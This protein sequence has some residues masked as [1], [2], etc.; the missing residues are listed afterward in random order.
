M[1]DNTRLGVPPAPGLCPADELRQS[2]SPEPKVGEQL[3]HY[4]LEQMI[5]QGGMGRVFRASDL[6]LG[7][8]L[9]LKVMLPDVAKDETHRH[10]F[11][12]EAGAMAALNHPHVVPIL[13]VD[14]AGPIPYFVMPLLHGETLQARLSRQPVLPV[15]DVIRIGRQTA[16]GLAHAHE[17]GLIHRDVKPAN[18]WLE[19]GSGQVKI[20]DFGLVRRDPE[21]IALTQTGMVLGTFGFMAPEQ[22]MGREVDHRCDQYSLGCTLYLACTGSRAAH[23]HFRSPHDLNANVPRRLG[24]VIMRLLSREPQDRFLKTGDVVEALSD[25]EQTSP[26][27]PPTASRRAYGTSS[28]IHRVKQTLIGV[29]AQAPDATRGES[30]FY[31][32]RQAHLAFAKAAGWLEEAPTGQYRLTEEG[33]RE[34]HS[35]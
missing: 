20:L 17:R 8:D 9:A 26:C 3:G 24:E 21:S 35:D 28:L 22:E 6:C 13:E 34:L 23:N 19:E 16:E 11:L 5:G 31:D 12:R 7:R 10:R 29:F 4:R 27:A 25:L 14:V 18:L 1:T 2:I 15:A 33:K 32:V 30:Y